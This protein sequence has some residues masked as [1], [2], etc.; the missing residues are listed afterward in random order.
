MAANNK[1]TFIV[2]RGVDAEVVAHK[3]EGFYDGVTI[4]VIRDDVG[5]PVAVVEGTPSNQKIF[6]ANAEIRHRISPERSG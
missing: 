2:P 4:K 6:E 3:L 1:T 5:L